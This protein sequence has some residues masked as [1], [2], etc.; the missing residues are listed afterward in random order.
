MAD[1]LIVMRDGKVV[2]QGPA[3]RIFE[4]PEHSYTR[5]LLAAEA[6]RRLDRARLD[7]QAS[8]RNS[9]R[10]IR[11]RPIR[12][13]SRYAFRV[14]ALAIARTGHRL[15]ARLPRSQAMRISLARAVLLATIWVASPAF[16]DPV[17]QAELT[18][19]VT[20]QK[21]H[22]NWVACMGSFNGCKTYWDF[23][24]DGTM[25]ARVIGAKPDDKCADDGKWRIEGTG[26]CWHLTWLGGG[27]GY[28]KVCVSLDKVG[29]NAY[30]AT[31]IGGLGLKFFE[32]S[33][34]K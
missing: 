16:A 33:V 18:R 10:R 9:R 20:G 1:D 23:H 21:W 24:K 8:L 2:E 5:A 27:E 25:C 19:L 12:T 14:R 13:R 32:A 17:G 29:E 30:V 11:V 31:R 3:E 6:L 34:A 22:M 26:L 7:R 4:Q 28:K 15:R